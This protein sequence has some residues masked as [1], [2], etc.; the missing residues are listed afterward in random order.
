ML[1]SY[2][3]S[4]VDSTGQAGICLAEGFSVV[5]GE[6]CPPTTA[7]Y[8]PISEPLRSWPSILHRA[9]TSTA[10]F[11]LLALTQTHTVGHKYPCTISLSV[12][13]LPRT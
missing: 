5:Q 10:Q 6:N 8:W 13:L 11:S 7:T 12:L 2:P 3:A 9:A 1:S 4:E